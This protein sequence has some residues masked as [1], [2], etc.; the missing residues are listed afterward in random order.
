MFVVALSFL[1]GSLR[2][3]PRRDIVLFLLF[4]QL[5]RLF[6]MFHLFEVEENL[7]LIVD[8]GLPVGANVLKLEFGFVKAFVG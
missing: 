7:L 5:H 8:F 4:I 6:V 1:K 2:G 3:D